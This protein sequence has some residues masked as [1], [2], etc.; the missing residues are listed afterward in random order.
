VPGIGQ[1]LLEEVWT[2]ERYAKLQPTEYLN[3]GEREVNQLEEVIAA[4]ASRL[5][6][7][8]TNS[9]PP[10]RDILV[11]LER[12][13]PC[14]AVVFDGLSIREI[15]VLLALAS[16]SGL[17]TQTVGVSLAALPSE[18]IAYIEQRLQAGSVAPSQLPRRRQMK[19]RKIEVYCYDN[20]NQQ[21]RLDTQSR[22]ILCWSMFPD[23]TY[24]D[25]GARFAQHFEQTHA[26]LQTA[27]LNI[28]QQ[29]P[30]GHKILITSDHG[31][32][33]F[34]SGLSFPYD[35]SSLRPLTEYFGGER[36]RNLSQTEQEVPNHPDVAV[37]PDRSVAV[38]RGRAQTHPPGKSAARLY[39][40]GGLSLMEMLTPWVV[41]EH[42]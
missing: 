31:Y 29:I 5:Y 40:H 42:T 39:K 34:G 12:E 33:Y 17:Q 21:H 4:S 6:D 25:S 18:T 41:L 2:A 15:P 28:V 3:K 10:D 37:L 30:R 20:P 32:V 14:A 19:D 22:A 7:E 26:L 38:I 24:S 23:N 11:F 16:K 13:R 8:M 27:W 36:Y 1:W 9:P 35:T